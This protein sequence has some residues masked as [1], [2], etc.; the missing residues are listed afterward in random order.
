M[1]E[2]K[3]NTDGEK[4]QLILTDLEHNKIFDILPSRKKE[5]VKEYLKEFQNRNEVEYFVMDMAGNYKDMAWLFPKAKVLVDKFHYV[6]QVYWALDNVRKRIQKQFIKEKRIYFKHSK[7]LLYK[8]YTKLER[9]EQQQLYNMLSQS[10]E[11]RQAWLLKEH[12]IDFKRSRTT[13]QA[14]KELHIWLLEAEEYEI[15]EFKAA[16]TA[17]HNWAREILNSITYNMTNARTEGYNNKIKVLKRNAY[18]YRSF[19]NFRRR[20]LLMA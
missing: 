8:D 16:T 5:Y 7:K 11:F 14:E 20:I 10:E 1:D 13:E 15:P 18:G 3:G 9:E 17:F 12:F 6:R 4:Y 2:F 19:E